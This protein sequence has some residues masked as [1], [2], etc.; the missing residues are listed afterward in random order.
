MPIIT[1]VGHV[2]RALE[3][4]NRKG[5]FF[6][7][8]QQSPWEDEGYPPAPSF[9]S[10]TVNQVLGYKAV[11]QVHLVVPDNVAGTIQYGSTKLRIV[12]PQ[13]ALS[14]KAKWVYVDASLDSDELPIGEYRQV[15]LFSGLQ[16]KVGVA[17]GKL[18]LLPSEVES[19]GILEVLDN[20]KVTKRALN[21][22][23][24]LKFL[25]QF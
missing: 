12:T 19:E 9:N 16:R 15:A 13:N 4:F 10:T 6:C 5:K 23:E 24:M 18:A 14:E 11:S 21:Q 7:V 3:F 17:A 20:K 8:G 1:E 22:K 25:I 2:R